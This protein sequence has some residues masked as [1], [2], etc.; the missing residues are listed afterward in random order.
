MVLY[1]DGITEAVNDREEMY[2][3]P[4]LIETIRKNAGSPSQVIVDEII[5]SVFAFTGA[6]PQFD[7]ITLMVVKAD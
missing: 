6:T 1:T 2:D 5:S 7:D 4:R 3:L